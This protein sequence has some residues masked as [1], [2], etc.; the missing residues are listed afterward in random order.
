MKRKKDAKSNS[1]K[2]MSLK[3]EETVNERRVG[4]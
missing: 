3:K 1:K 2:L 4:G